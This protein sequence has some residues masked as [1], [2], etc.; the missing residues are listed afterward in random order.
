MHCRTFPVAGNAPSTF[1]PF[2]QM[3]IPLRVASTALLILAGVF[4]PVSFAGTGGL[5]PAEA[6]CPTCCAEEGSLCYV[7]GTNSCANVTN[8]YLKSSP[9]PCN[10]QM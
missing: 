2:V 3:R 1:L 6:A 8:A 4:A 5:K 7:C 9:G 10:L